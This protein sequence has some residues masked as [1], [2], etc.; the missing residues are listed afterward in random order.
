MSISPQEPAF[1]RYRWVRCVKCMKHSKAAYPIREQRSKCCQHPVRTAT[2]K[3][4]AMPE[5]ARVLRCLWE[6]PGGVPSA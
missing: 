3:W 5:A 6:E 4:W 1:R 2:W